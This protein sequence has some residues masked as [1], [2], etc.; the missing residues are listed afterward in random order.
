MRPQS[1][2]LDHGPRPRS[3][4]ELADLAYAH[5]TAVL[6]PVFD[7]TLVAVTAVRRGGRSRTAVLGHARAEALLRDQDAPDLEV[8]APFD[9]TDL[10]RMLAT[11]RPAVERAI[12][13][14]DTRYGL[15]RGAFGRALG[16]PASDAAARAAS[17][18]STWQSE[19]D[20]IV[21]AHLGP[22]T[23]PELAVILT[24]GRVWQSPPPPA[25]DGELAAGTIVIDTA[26]PSFADL[27]AVGPA[28]ADHAAGCEPCGDRLRSMVS[29]RD[30]L[31]Q[32]PVA[33]APHEVK[34]A[35]ASHRLRRPAA[36]SPP[37]EPTARASI[38]APRLM[39]ALAFGV[40]V[41]LVVGA[42]IRFGHTGT[43]RQDRVAALTRTPSAGTG[44]A[45]QPTE[46]QLPDPSSA[47]LRNSSGE[48]LTWRAAPDQPWM[49]VVPSTGRLKNGQSVAL[50][51]VV[52]RA[53]P[54]GNQRCGHRDRAGWF[55]GRV[56][57]DGA[58]RSRAGRC[59]I[60]CRL[61]GLRVGRR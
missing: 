24:E 29:I 5:A 23:C 19:L 37:L 52:G 6:G 10:A 14:L 32:A 11:T 15:D 44:L 61:R 4:P 25:Q 47:I 60:G 21:L 20:P 57:G 48:T 55:D 42:I 34:D 54:E 26:V 43:T 27:I 36:A 49:R 30:L 56:A 31:A 41:M 46:T 1:A 58:D 51:L 3:R 18:F 39:A 53:A 22:G 12:A 40:L 8:A 38:R 45:F 50:S 13:D 2:S 35:S 17:T 28:V 59:D 33:R 9:L 16:L 7:A